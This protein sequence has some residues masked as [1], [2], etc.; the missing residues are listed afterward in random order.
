MYPLRPIVPKR[1]ILLVEDHAMVREGMRLLFEQ[2]GLECDAVEVGSLAEATKLLSEQHDFDW[3]LLDLGLPD[4]GGITALDRLRSAHPDVPVVV[5]SASEDRVLVLDCINRGAMG[6]IGKSANGA[7]LIDALRLVFN[8][9][10]HLPPALFG[11]PAPAPPTPFVVATD[12]ELARLGLTPRQIEVLSLLVQGL[13]NRHIAARLGL[14]EATVKTH[15]AAG[16]RALNVKNRTQAVFALA[17]WQST[18]RPAAS[19]E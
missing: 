15:V 19:H 9:G 18:K 11:T 8:G 1:K 12:A 7:A 2:Q 4:A 5:L 16:L 10:V 3:V 6:F 14:S 17:R 13:T